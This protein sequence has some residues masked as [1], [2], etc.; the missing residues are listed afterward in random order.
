LPSSWAN[1]LKKSN[2]KQQDKPVNYKVTEDKSITSDFPQR[3]SNLKK[4]KPEVLQEAA[5]IAR[6]NY[7]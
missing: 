3:L 1:Q 6:H 4:N 5:N 7:K 2:I